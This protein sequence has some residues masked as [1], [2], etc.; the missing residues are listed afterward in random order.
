VGS[1]SDGES[2]LEGFHVEDGVERSCAGGSESDLESVGQ[3]EGVAAEG[4]WELKPA[5]RNEIEERVAAEELA[6]GYDLSSDD[7][8]SAGGI[9]DEAFSADLGS[10]SGKCETTG[11]KNL[12][13][14]SP[15][16]DVARGDGEGDLAA[17]QHSRA[18][19]AR[20]DSQGAEGGDEAGIEND[21][22]LATTNG[23]NLLSMGD[24]G[25]EQDDGRDWTGKADF[26]DETTH[27]DFS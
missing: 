19:G 23:V 14:S 21:G 12:G 11:V 16:I 15:G 27:F 17:S 7:G 24:G 6:A 22:G 4:E 18:D 25:G 5:G 8:L 1:A 13:A 26:A 3:M 9:N 2:G 20:R 10:A